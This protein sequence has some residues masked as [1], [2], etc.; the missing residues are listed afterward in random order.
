MKPRKP[1]LLF[2]LLLLTPFFSFAS[3]P[4]QGI[5]VAGIP[6][7][8]IFFGITLLGVALFHHHTLL[9]SLSGLGIV[10]AYKL[11][12]GFNIGHHL[13]EE[14]EILANLFGLLLGFAILAKHF[15]D[16]GIPELLPNYLPDDW[17]GGFALLLITFIL[18]SFLDNIASA[19]IGGM[20]AAHVF[21]KKVHLGFLAAIV[22][23]S[24]AGGAGSVLGDTTTTMMW[25]DGISPLDVLEAFIGGFAALLIFGLPAS[26]QQDHYN[27]IQRDAIPG[28]KIDYAKLLIVLLILIGAITF[29]VLLDF[30]ALGVW[31]AILIGAIFRKT[32]WNELKKAFPGTIFLLSL[33]F[34]ASMMP[35]EKLPHASWQT[36]L[37]L[38]FISSVF[39]NIPLTKLALTQGGF[40]WGILAYCVGFGGSMIWFGSSA[41]VALSN[42]FPEARSVGNWIK[43]GWHVIIGYVVG[44]FV[45]FW[46]MGW[47]PIENLSAKPGA[48][49]DVAVKI[50]NRDH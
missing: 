37:A 33:V 27:R 13:G 35:V 41:G 46:I 28:V 24:N 4:T 42:I 45:L 10:S 48:K 44:F 39:D 20:I 34:L 9:V 29:N 49:K 6:I 26:F 5:E 38:G 7:E 8:F 16:S 2:A 25:I 18:S 36:A 22:A 31:G 50:K 3:D 21:K 11:I 1:V 15:E 47:H 40:D 32:D 19:M 14:W 43:N 17:K 12:N 30:P 23:A